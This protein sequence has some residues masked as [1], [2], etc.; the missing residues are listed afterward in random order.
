MSSFPRTLSDALALLQP[1]AAVLAVVYALVTTFVTAETTPPPPPATP[2]SGSTRAEGY[3]APSF[4]EAEELE[5]IRADF[6]TAVLDLR[7]NE[8][9]IGP[10]H[11]DFNLQRVAQEHAEGNAV[12]NEEARIDAPVAMVQNNKPAYRAN[13]YVLLDDFLHSPAHT[14]V[15]LDPRHE[16]IGIGVAQGHD[17]VWVVVAF[18]Q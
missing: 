5:K 17:R 4:D 7:A 1:F 18:S 15:L 10:V 16:N 13:A 12:T 8:P 6:F 14:R 9:G 3:V 11:L 2:D